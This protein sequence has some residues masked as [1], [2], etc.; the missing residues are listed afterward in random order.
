MSGRPP[1]APERTGWNH[2][3]ASGAEHARL[4]KAPVA[5]RAV[6]GMGIG[7]PWR[8][9]AV[10][11]RKSAHLLNL[12]GV[13]GIFGPRPAKGCQPPLAARGNLAVSVCFQAVA[14]GI[15]A[16]GG[17]SPNAALHLDRRGEHGCSPY[18]V[19]SGR[20]HPDVLERRDC[21]VGWGLLAMTMGTDP[22]SAE[23]G[24]DSGRRSAMGCPPRPAAPRNDD[25]VSRLTSHR[26]AG[27]GAAA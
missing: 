14:P 25:R 8:P 4:H 18:G 21:F 16:G 22:D 7:C 20:P 11:V 10:K 5:P 9:A 24:Y 27:P 23:N 3:G 1:G 12:P 19:F 26:N 17:R 15:P 6:G 2:R 13:V